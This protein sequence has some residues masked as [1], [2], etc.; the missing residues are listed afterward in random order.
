MVKVSLTVSRPSD[1]VPTNLETV[2]G[3]AMTSM[4]D[5]CVKFREQ[6]ELDTE[7]TDSR[8]WRWLVVVGG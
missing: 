7:H 4:G 1:T 5:S 3:Q 8:A 6:S 2:M